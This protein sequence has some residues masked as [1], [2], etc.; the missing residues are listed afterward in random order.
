MS[1]ASSL[2]EELIQTLYSTWQRVPLEGGGY[3]YVNGYYTDSSCTAGN[4]H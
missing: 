4:V 2:M 3:C 1:V